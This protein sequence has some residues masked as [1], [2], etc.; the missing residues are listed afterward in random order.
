MAHHRGRHTRQPRYLD[1]VA[2]AGRAG[3]HLV[4]EDDV[5]AALAGGFGRADVHV[6]GGV[7]RGRELGQLE[8]MG[9]EQRK[10]FGPVVQLRGDAG[11]QRQA[12]EGAGATADF[13]H[14]HQR[15]SRS[16]MQDLRGL[17][18]L[19][20]EGRLRIG[21]IVGCAD[22]RVDGVDRP[23]PA[24][25]RRHVRAD[26][27]QQHDHR[28]LPHVGRL[29]THVRAGDDLHALLRTQLRV[30]GDEG[31]RRLLGQPRLDHR[32]AA[33]CDFDARMGYEGRRVPPQRVRAFG[34]GAQRIERGD[35]ASQP[36][37]R[38]NVGLQRIEQLLVQPLLA[39]QCAV[40]RRQRLV[41]EGLEFGRDEALGV[42]QRLAPDVIGRNFAER[43][44]RDLDVEAV[45]A[46]ELHAQVGNA[47]ALALAHFELQQEV[48]AVLADGDQFV[49]LRVVAGGEHATVAHQR[50][51]LGPDGTQQQ[52][53][54]TGRWRQVHGDVGEQR[55]GVGQQRRELIGL[56]QR[57]P[58]CDQFAR[59]HLA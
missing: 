26:G 28:D 44:L 15:L 24:G 20:H 32:M 30:V 53:G 5:A 10:G 38:G 6:D 46:V 35:G 40:L 56:G 36:R 7:V 18:H 34:Q 54:A 48:V 4:Q 42:L 21:Q 19:Q 50:R 47:A 55:I 37:E 52:L 59:P 22:A 27:R 39:C 45:H 43:T 2:L 33:G 17:G 31:A 51:R 3:L 25:R 11:G 14:Q 1:A 29:A 23:E 58:Q 49:Q 9:G 57:Q 12:V 16:A 41:L 13:I 8:V